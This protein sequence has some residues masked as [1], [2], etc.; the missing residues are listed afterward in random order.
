MII[1]LFYYDDRPLLLL[2]HAGACM[3]THTCMRMHIHTS[4]CACMYV[5]VHMHAHIYTL[6]H[7]HAYTRIC[8]LVVSNISSYMP[9]AYHH[10]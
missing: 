5:R 3:R 4:T 2:T 7:V 9:N 6:V 8:M 1:G 10:A